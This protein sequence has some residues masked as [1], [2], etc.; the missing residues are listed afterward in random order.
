[1][2]MV[3]REK[4]GGGNW[5]DRA[6]RAVGG[7]RIRGTGEGLASRKQT[8][9][10]GSPEGGGRGTQDAGQSEEGVAQHSIFAEKEQAG[11]G[12]RGWGFRKE[13]PFLRKD[14]TVDQKQT[15]KIP[16]DSSESSQPWK[17][18]LL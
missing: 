1:M 3:K 13:V 5:L 18:L 14:K 8:P 7:D 16:H 4:T 10:P 15:Q 9:P 12:P 11:C 17:W 2:V 6:R